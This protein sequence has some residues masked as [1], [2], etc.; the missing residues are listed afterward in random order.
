MVIVML[1]RHGEAVPPSVNEERP[2]TQK[3]KEDVEAVASCIERPSIIISSP[4]LR[5][6]QTG[7]ILSKKLGVALSISD[8]L[9][10]ERFSVDSLLRILKPGALLIGHN[11]SLEEVLDAL[12]IRANLP[13][14]SVAAVNIIEKKLLWLITPSI[15]K[16][17]LERHN[18]TAP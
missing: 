11:P 12:G 16:R 10:P 8:E 3:G 1:M 17:C 13:T 18:S 2:L 6:R 9:L 4:L 14:A 15:C 5:A 7:E